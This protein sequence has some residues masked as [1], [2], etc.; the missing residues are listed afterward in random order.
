MFAFREAV[1]QL[2]CSHYP[3]LRLELT[4]ARYHASNLV[5]PYTSETEYSVDVPYDQRPYHTT[6]TPWP[7]SI[8]SK[9]E[10]S[11]YG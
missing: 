4:S 7:T 2:G 11:N 9:Q 1:T 10:S 3:R 8:V 6:S 5:V